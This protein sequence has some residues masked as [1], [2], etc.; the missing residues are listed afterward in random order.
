[1]RSKAL[2]IAFGLGAV[3]TNAFGQI[4]AAKPLGTP[5]AA[6]VAVASSAQAPAA[7]T[8]PGSTV[9]PAAPAAPGVV[10]L[11]DMA[12]QG[13]EPPRAAGH[14]PAPS[15][16]E[17][18]AITI[19]DG[20]GKPLDAA[21]DRLRTTGS[22]PSAPRTNITLSRISRSGGDATAVLW[23]KG[24]HRKVTN[25]SRVLNYTVG[26]IKEDGVCLY[27]AKGKVKDKCRTMITFLQGV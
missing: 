7:P 19:L 6:P 18:P 5:S 26:E 24:Q 20:N 16:T 27:P 2:A 8:T 3:A 14:P 13:G 21:R 10:T 1:M 4:N 22:T 17:V 25:G 9:A 11:S 15:Q 12:R 23:V